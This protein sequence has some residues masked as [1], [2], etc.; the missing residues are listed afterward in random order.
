MPARGPSTRNSGFAPGASGR[1]APSSQQKAAR[2]WPGARARRGGD[3]VLESTSA[4]GPAAKVSS[5]LS[6][7]GEAQHSRTTRITAR[8]G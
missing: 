4:V 8:S 1:P 5:K 2:G 7:Q 6:A 3:L